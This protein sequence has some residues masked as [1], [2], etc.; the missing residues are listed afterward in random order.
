MAMQLQGNGGVLAE[1]DGV[2]FRALRV[3]IRPIEYGALGCYAYAHLSGT[4]AAGLGANAEIFQ[5][6]WT[7]GTRFACIYLVELEGMAGS[8]TAFTAGFCNIDLIIARAWSVV[9]SGG[10]AATLT[11]DNSKLRTSMGTMLMQDIRGS[12]TAAL[13]AG[14]KTLDSNRIGNV[15]WSVGTTASLIYVPNNTKL[16][17]TLEMNHPVVLAGTGGGEGIAVRATVPATGTW[18]FGMTAH[19]AEVQA[20]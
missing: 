14:T 11:G 9:G 15:T 13:T 6:R 19:W 4:M 18:Q 16:F 3:T 17:E 20:F 2:G 1:V 12:S 10:T 8:A 7:D 5:M